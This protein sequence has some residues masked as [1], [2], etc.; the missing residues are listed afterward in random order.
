MLSSFEVFFWPVFMVQFC[1]RCSAADTQLK[2]LHRVVNGA[3]FLTG[4]VFE[5]DIS[6]RRSVAVLCMLYKIRWDQMHP[7]YLALPGPYMWHY[8]LHAVLW[9]HIGILQGSLQSPAVYRRPVIPQA[10]YHCGT[11]LVTQYS[12]VWDWQ[13]NTVMVLQYSYCFPFLFHSMGWYCVARV[14]GLIG[15]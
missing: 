9:S 13:G 6:H 14:F 15:C 1:N 4:G 8:R 11:I 7:F 10:V 12:M 2:L 3:I 5:C